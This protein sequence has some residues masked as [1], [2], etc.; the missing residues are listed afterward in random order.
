MRKLM[1]FGV[2]LGLVALSIPAHAVSVNMC[3]TKPVKNPTDL[4]GKGIYCSSLSKCTNPNG[5][6]G[7]S[8]ASAPTCGYV[9]VDPKNPKTGGCIPNPACYPGTTSTPTPTPT[10]SPTPSPK[11][12]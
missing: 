4:F 1:L 7:G 3:S 9:P 11:P 8:G 6:K 2:M 5:K 10:P 12:S